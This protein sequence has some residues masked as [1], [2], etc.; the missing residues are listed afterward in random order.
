MTDPIQQAL[1]TPK[2]APIMAQAGDVGPDM[3]DDRR[4][5]PPFP[6]G[7][8]VKCLGVSGDLSG[9]QTCYYLDY[10]G[11]LV[12]LE[13]GNRH[14]KNSMIFLY[15]PQSDWLEAHFPQWSAPV[16]EGRGKDR[17]LKKPSEII[18]FDQAEA[19]RAMIEECVRRGIFNPAG[20]MRGAGAHKLGHQGLVVHFG[21]KLLAADLRVDG[22]VKGFKWHD[23]GLFDQHVYQ[24]ATPIPRPWHEPT[25]TDPAEKLL[26]L[27][28]MWNWRRP[29]LDPRFMLGWIGAA[30][31]GGAL[32]WRPNIWLTGGRG[33]GKSSLNGRDQV[34][35]QLLGDG[36]FRTGNASAA[37][38]RQSLKNSTVPVLF[39]EIEASADNRRVKE[40]VELARVSS[41]GDTVHRGG[42]DHKAHEFTLASCFQFSSILI[43]PLEPQDRSRLGILELEP[44]VPGSIAPV[45]S[46]WNLPELGK[47]LQ[48]RMIDG[49]TQLEETLQA[50]KAAMSLTGHDARACMQFGTL[51]AC[52]HLLLHDE[53]PSEEEANEWAARCRPESMAE[54]SEA[55]SEESDCLSHITTSLVQARGGDEREALGSWI[56]QLVEDR[57]APLLA[58]V[59]GGGDPDRADRLDKRLQQIGLKLVNASHKPE[60]RG[61]DGKVSRAASW[62]AVQY[63]PGVPGFLAVAGKHNGLS[64]IF[65]DTKWSNGVWRQ[66]LARS[67]DSIDGVRVRFGH[68]S[69]RA[70]L[71]PLWAVVDEMILP[72]ASTPEKLRDWIAEQKKG[73][74]T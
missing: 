74:G 53:P 37:A 38:I 67:S 29:L 52:A 24:A 15:G 25:S 63:H 65:R 2:P 43:P 36:V 42:A 41:S 61:V 13:A 14:G 20:R 26:Q 21:D 72:D 48:R 7:S 3:A 8:P 1:D 73:A 66:A 60:Q 46:E 18:G 32:E 62:G 57:A 45:L 59:V 28:R 11:Q 47:H 19:S 33:T 49:W 9:S 44:F 54:I 50:F 22:S 64:A 71:V 58:G 56:G 16:Y 34:L 12:G 30:M 40:V 10:N 31:I 39:D 55:T 69:Q 51:L 5:R 68:Q 35:H 23:A 4:E 70:V 27:L 17:E 6:P